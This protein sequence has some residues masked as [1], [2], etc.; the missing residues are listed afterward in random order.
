[1]TKKLLLLCCLLTAPLIIAEVILPPGVGTGSGAGSVTTN[2]FNTNQ[3]VADSIVSMKDGAKFTNVQ[4]HGTLDLTNGAGS[5]SLRLNNFSGGYISLQIPPGFI[6]T[7][8]VSICFSNT[9]VGDVLKVSSIASS[10]GLHSVILTNG[11]ESGGA[12]TP[13]GDS[14]AV[15]FNE[16]GAFAGTNFL[17]YHRTN[18]TLKI[19][20]T[21]AAAT[22]ETRGKFVATNTSANQSMELHPQGLSFGNQGA[23]DIAGGME[24]GGYGTNL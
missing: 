4:H 19:S 9:A 24:F 13:S 18:N 20:G 14:G 3:F 8:K 10:L 17:N 23:M 21:A 2:S 16:G 1:M 12:G 15:Q 22:N 11:P 7:N 6:P 5:A